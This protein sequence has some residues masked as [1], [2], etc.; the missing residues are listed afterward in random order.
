M[1]ELVTL[2]IA[3]AALLTSAVSAYEMVLQRRNAVRPVLVLLDKTAESADAA[4]GRALYLVN[5]GQA[6]AINVAILEAVPDQL[7]GESQ[8][9]LRE[10]GPGR[11][12]K[13]HAYPDGEPTPFGKPGTYLRATYCDVNGAKYQTVYRGETGHEFPPSRGLLARLAGRRRRH[14]P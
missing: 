11:R 9:A 10:I 14:D 12:R 1:T 13:L 5:M 3:C 6:V 8:V 4:K 2:T 7:R